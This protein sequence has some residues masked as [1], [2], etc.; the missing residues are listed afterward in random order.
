MIDT[1]MPNYLKFPQTESEERTRELDRL[2]ELA[3][4]DGWLNAV[5]Q[6][7]DSIDYMTSPVRYKFLDLLPLNKE[8]T[9]LEIGA[10]HGQITT[11]LARRVGFVHALEVVP[12][13]ARFAAERCR[14][15]GLDNAKVA[16][17]VDDCQLPFEDGQFNGV[18]LN[19][20]LEW[21]GQRDPSTP[22]VESQKKLLRE[23]WRVLK[24][25]G[26]I[27]LT[28]KNRYG[29]VLLHGVHDPH[30]FNWRFGQAMPRWLISLLGRLL[31][32]SRPEGMIHSYPTLH[33]LVT[34]AGFSN[35]KPYWAVPDT[36]YRS[37][38]EIVPADAES[39]RAARKRPDFKHG[40][41]TKAEV[42]FKLTP[43]PLVKYLTSSLTF[44]A[45][46]PA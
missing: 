44:F 30:T 42:M 8:S 25:G 16:C 41:Y 9:I 31:G 28:T 20:V 37:P 40:S 17:G 15:E 4:R 14:Q 1:E 3:V 27:Y 11:A 5:K 12:Q 38:T 29:M 2:N 34:E 22:H 18:V 36:S 45:E 24:P 46:K 13:F 7:Y 10:Q 39:I 43:A 33:R 21:C 6:T 19:L 32:K 26:W 23:C 35:L